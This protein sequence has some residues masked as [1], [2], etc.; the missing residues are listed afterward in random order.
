MFSYPQAE[1]TSCAF[2]TIHETLPRSKLGYGANDVYP[3]FPPLMSDGR[4]V[5]A[6]HQP[7]ATLNSNLIAQNGITSNWQ[8]RKFLTDNSQQIAKQNFREACTDAGYFERFKSGQMGN[9]DPIQSAPFKYDSYLQNT[10]P[11]GYSNS[12]LKDM[13]LSR[14]DLNARKFS[15]SVTQEQLF[16]SMQR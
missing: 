12:D 16:A 11:E 1:T 3:G 6:S 15:P 4:T 7:E 8:Y 5:V 14:E 9:A 13:Y 2:P 10:K